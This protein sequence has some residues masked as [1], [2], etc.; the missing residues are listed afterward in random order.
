MHIWLAEYLIKGEYQQVRGKKA[1]MLY[2]Y[3]SLSRGQLWA[4]WLSEVCRNEKY[5]QWVSLKWEGSS[6]NN[7]KTQSNKINPL[8]SPEFVLKF[9]LTFIME[10]STTQQ[11][12]LATLPPDII[13]NIISF[14]KAEF[15]QREVSTYC[16]RSDLK[17]KK[18]KIK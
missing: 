10:P 16:L 3:H 17:S 8:E 13:R 1:L 9:T 4:V 15:Q 18:I 14:A 6:W 2:E 7:V 11:I 12:G 5:A